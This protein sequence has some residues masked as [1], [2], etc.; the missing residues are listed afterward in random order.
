MS[1]Q[2]HE[3]YTAPSG[4]EASTTE[5]SAG[6]IQVIQHVSANIKHARQQKGWSQVHLAGLAGVSRRMLV[7]IEA[8]E[9]NVSIATVDR[10]A[11][12]LGVSF[13]RIVR[14]PQQDPQSAMAP[15]RVWQGK[16]PSSHATLLQSVPSGGTTVELWYWQLAPGDVYQSEADPVGYQ[17]IHYV[18]SGELS[19]I[20]QGRVHVVRAGESFVFAS[21]ATYAYQNKGQQLLSFTRNMLMAL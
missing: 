21:Q 18:I 17:E 1:G 15:I 14:A 6:H 3:Q 2:Q 12:A 16:Q 9:S 7:N 11:N 19:L 8:G 10:L 20:T 4:M 5:E 13:D